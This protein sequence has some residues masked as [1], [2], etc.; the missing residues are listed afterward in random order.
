[1]TPERYHVYDILQAVV[2]FVVE[3]DIVNEDNNGFGVVFTT[4]RASTSDGLLIPKKIYRWLRFL[5]IPVKRRLKYDFILDHIS[6]T[7]TTDVNADD[8]Q[9]KMSRACN[10]HGELI[11]VSVSKM[12]ASISNTNKPSELMKA[13]RTLL[14]IPAPAEQNMMV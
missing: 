5:L 11:S 1:M 10:I 13:L 12:L 9:P 2:V 8:R 7:T 6:P 4:S 3:I 14:I